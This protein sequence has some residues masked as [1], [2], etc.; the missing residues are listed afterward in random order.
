MDEDGTKVFD[1]IVPYPVL[2]RAAE[3]LQEAGLHAYT[4][5][6]LGHGTHQ[7]LM[8]PVRRSPWKNSPLTRRYYI[9]AVPKRVS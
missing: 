2:P 3:R 6:R 9:V 5:W 8:R 4:E 1:W 7:E